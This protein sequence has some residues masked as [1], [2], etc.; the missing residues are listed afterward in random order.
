MKTEFYGKTSNEETL[1]SN[2]AGDCLTH[3]GEMK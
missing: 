1:I 3:I 2:W